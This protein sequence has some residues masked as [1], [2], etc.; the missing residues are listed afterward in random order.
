MTSAR[1]STAL[2]YLEASNVLDLSAIMSLRSATC[3][4]IFAPG[5]RPPV[6]NTTYEAGLHRFKDIIFGFPVTVKEVMEDEKLN[7]IIF[8][9]S[10]GVRWNPAAK[11]PGLSEEEWNFKGEYMIVLSM[12]ETGEKIERVLEFVDSKATEYLRTLMARAWVNIQQK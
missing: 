12:D 3:T 9:A 6:D 8:W 11:D 2:K 10:G 1:Y 5:E 7:R 4:H